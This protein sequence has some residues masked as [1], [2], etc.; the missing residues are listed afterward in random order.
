MDVLGSGYWTTREDD[1]VGEP[2][3]LAHGYAQSKWVAEQLVA[4]ARDRGIP[5]AI[6]RPGRVIGHSKTGVW[7]TDD[8]ACRAIRGSIELGVV[9]DIDPLD[10]MTPV[11]YVARA[12]VRISKSERAFTHRAFH[13]IAPQYVLWRD[14]FDLMRR[15]GY[16][17]DV[18]PYREWRKRLSTAPDNA[19]APLLPIFPVPP[20]EGDDGSGSRWRDVP[21]PN[22]SAVAAALA[23]SGVE[24]PPLDT[25]LWDRYFTFFLGTGYIAPVGG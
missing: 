24:C 21:S 6:Y 16:A 25:T 20:E 7:N 2:D 22:C 4:T 18:V 12:I 1:L 13:V 10:S 11:D 23:G 9:P 8:L 15:R 19:L 17:L 5:A 14:L 3:A